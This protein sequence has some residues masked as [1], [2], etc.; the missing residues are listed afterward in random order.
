MAIEH[1]FREYDIRGVFGDELNEQTT[2]IIG[3]KL[4]EVMQNMGVRTLC[5]GYDA[6][7]SAKELFLWLISGLEKSK[8]E[9]FDIGM[10]PTPVG[11]FANFS[12]KFDANIMITGSHNP[13]EYNGFKITIFKDSYFGKN[14]QILKHFVLENLSVNVSTSNAKIQK[15]DILSDYL[16]FFTKEFAH[17]KGFNVPFVI[18]CGNGVAGICVKKICDALNLNARILF[19]EPDGNFPN[20]H[21]DPT[22]A[23][24]LIDLKREMQNSSVNLGFAFDGDADRIAVLL[25]NHNIK[26]D[27]LAC[28]FSL[29]MKNPRI[30]GEVKCSQA[31]FDF[32]RE[33]GGEAF[34]GK[35]GH[36]NI[37]KAIKEQNIDLGA[38]VSGHIFFKERYFGFDDAI[39]AMM[40][41]L[42]LVYLGFDL[43]KELEKLPKFHSSDEIKIKTNEKI[44]FL[45]VELIKN[46]IKNG[47]KLGEIEEIIT[48]DGVRVHFKDVKNRGWALIRASNTTPVLVTRFEANSKQFLD[49]IE[50][51]FTDL[52]EQSIKEM[53]IAR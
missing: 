48:I 39:Y 14:L 53:Q 52:I 3:L 36:S 25:P 16:Q 46:K 50:R 10:A 31:M 45:L 12:G 34:M 33:R 38:E 11:Y 30:L 40:R 42:E 43:T 27:E 6:R 1:I 29:N 5:V 35:T 24:N 28:L 8:I 13:K 4:G 32:V 7:L 17:L 18:D 19:C 49:E 9:I 37:K 51:F 44:K 20:H 2:K 15:I 23:E 41:V 22:I 26:G 21:P 47:I